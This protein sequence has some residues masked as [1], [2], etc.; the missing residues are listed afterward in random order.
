VQD[1]RL[2]SG[3]ARPGGSQKPEFDFYREYGNAVVPR[4]RP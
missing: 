3:R 4:F 1:V 2:R